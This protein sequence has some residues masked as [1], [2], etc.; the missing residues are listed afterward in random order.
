MS[1][2]RLLSAL[3]AS[4]LLLATA[5]P[6]SAAPSP[7]IGAGQVWPVETPSVHVA[8]GVT[9]VEF[10]F[11]G[12]HPICLADGTLVPSAPVAGHIWQRIDADGS[13]FLRFDETL[14]YDGGELRYRGNATSNAGGWQSAVRTVG[15]SSGALSGIVGQ[16]TFSPIEADGSFTDEIYYTYR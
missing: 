8:D 13:I 5:I 16:G 6:A 12:V 14:S 2:R 15:T 9:F 3:L 7:C 10:D 1:T 11:A 4:G